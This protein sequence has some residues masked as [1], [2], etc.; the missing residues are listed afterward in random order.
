MGGCAGRELEGRGLA[1]LAP[2]ALRSMST[3]GPAVVAAGRLG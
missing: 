2:V 1:V 3:V